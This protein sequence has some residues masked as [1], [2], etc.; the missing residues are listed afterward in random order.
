MLVQDLYSAWIDQGLNWVA[1]HG[2]E[3]AHTPQATAT[4]SPQGLSL[5]PEQLQLITDYFCKVGFRSQHQGTQHMT[6]TC[7]TCLDVG[8]HRCVLLLL[9]EHMAG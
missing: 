5:S 1:L 9:S 3:N 4:Q 6:W 7:A 8:P 2:Q